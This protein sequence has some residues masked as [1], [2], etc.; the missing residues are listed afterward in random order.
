M[1]TDG[2]DFAEIERDHFRSRLYPGFAWRAFDV[3]GLELED[4][5]A[6]LRRQ[7]PLVGGG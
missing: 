1:T 7:A 4:G 5:P 6:H 2:V 3:L